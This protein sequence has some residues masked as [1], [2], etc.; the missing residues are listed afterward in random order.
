MSDNMGARH[1]KK[2]T[3]PLRYPGGK[4]RALNKIQPFMT[5][6]FSEYREPF[7]G[8]GSVFIYLKQ[9]RPEAKFRI[10]D[11]NFDLFCFWNTLKKNVDDL[12]TEISKIKNSYRNGRVLYEE[13]ARAPNDL[14]EFHR[15]V[16]FYVLNRITYSGTVDSGGYSAESF[17][18]RFTVTNMEKL[19]PA[20]S[21]LQDVEI[22]NQ[23]YENILSR[24]GKRVFVFLDPPYLKTRRKA[25]YGINGDLNKSF[26]HLEFAKNVKQCR[27]KWLITYDDSEGIRNLFSPVE[28][29][30]L[31]PWEL[32]YG[33]NNAG[34]NKPAKGKELLISNYLP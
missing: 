12:L 25:L 18:K 17:K 5:L 22:T 34:N 19:K 3:S 10:N 24:N 15:A 26:N 6:D 31:H 33:M 13:L 1:T 11:L 23:S 28:K 4:S 2:V 14:D 21:L 29:V 16:R 9:V 27:H 32:Q 30:H 20:S 7:V 8:G